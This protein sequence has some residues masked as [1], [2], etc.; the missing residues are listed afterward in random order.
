VI[1][2]SPAPTDNK[3]CFPEGILEQLD[4]NVLKQHMRQE[5]ASEE[6]IHR[7][8]EIF[9]AETAQRVAWMLAQYADTPAKVVAAVQDT[10]VACAR[11]HGEAIG[12]DV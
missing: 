11:I 6:N 2:S 3:I 12:Q 1:I 8:S 9:R 5:E 10:V 4:V 7:M